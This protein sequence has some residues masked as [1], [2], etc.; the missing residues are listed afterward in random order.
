[1]DS[2]RALCINQQTKGFDFL[3]FFLHLQPHFPRQGLWWFSSQDRS[4][5]WV[6]VCVT[7]LFTCAS[8]CP[9]YSLFSSFKS[10]LEQSS[11]CCQSLECLVVMSSQSTLHVLR[12]TLLWCQCCIQNYMLFYFVHIFRG[13]LMKIWVN[14]FLFIS[15]AAV[16]FIY[17][18]LYCLERLYL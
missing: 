7:D 10:G 18:Y 3:V 17:V 4:P 6:C 11:R 5:S 15:L 2:I 16:V 13:H 1:M 14:M 12:R 9:L 8:C